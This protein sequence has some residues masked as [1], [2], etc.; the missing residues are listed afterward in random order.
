MI[1]ATLSDVSKAA[2]E[3]IKN[4]V[5]HE[6]NSFLEKIERLE[7]QLVEKER[8]IREREREILLEIYNMK[9][10]KKTRH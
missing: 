10:N 8:M 2:M 6:R 9:G 7:R 1:T 4:R 3:E 5:Q